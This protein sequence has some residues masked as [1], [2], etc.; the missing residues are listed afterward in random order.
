MAD[1]G[2][3]WRSTAVEGVLTATVTA[4]GDERGSFA[5]LWRTAWTAPLIG[6]PFVQ[7]NLSRS[8][9]DVLRGLHLHRR[10]WDLWSVVAGEGTAAVVDTRPLLDRGA[11]AVV[12]R[13][14]FDM[15]P[16]SQLLIPPYV[17]HG[18]HARTELVLVYLVT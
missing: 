3:R 5:E 13:E 8:K 6:E 17:A 2:S 4:D 7:A 12:T 1:E 15:S 18:F 16:G 9:A 14:T 10:Q 11:H